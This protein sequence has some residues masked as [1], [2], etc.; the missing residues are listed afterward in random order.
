[1]KFE[2]IT[3]CLD[4]RGCPNRCKHCWLGNTPNGC[5]TSENLRYVANQFRPFT[6][7][8]EVYDWYREPDY[9]N[10]YKEMWDLCAE[11]SDEHASHFELVSFWRLVRDEEY[12][13]WLAGLG[14]KYAQLTLFGDESV[15]DY[16]VGRRG[17]YMEILKAIDILLEN[18]ICPR[19]QMFLNEQNLGQLE[20]VE[21]LVGELEL[22]RR[23]HEID[24]EFS[25]FLHAGS[26]DGANEQFYS[27]R[28]TSQML[29]DIPEY[30]TELTLKY[31]GEKDIHD[32]FG[33]PECMLYEELIN[34]SFVTDFVT[35][36]P[37]FY[38]DKDFNVY[39]NIT[40]P[41]KYW[42][43][44]NLK[45]DRVEDVIYNY[46][47]NKCLAAEISAS[48]PINQLVRECGSQNGMGMFTKD[49]YIIFILNKYCKPLTKI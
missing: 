7:N 38:I 10:D 12:A 2:K 49:D 15:T 9:G 8:L 37:V 46:K 43:L 27:Q 22:E 5:L 40:A 42:C 47:N 11:L 14:V 44:G 28:V 48:V 13:K 39:P 6:G 25:F 4:I 23:C 26:C 24:G 1:M 30:L 19:I 34:D 32:V 17:A 36:S 35:D 29:D 33:K 45:R 20:F 16:F 41:A 3:I 31:L 18:G 21:K